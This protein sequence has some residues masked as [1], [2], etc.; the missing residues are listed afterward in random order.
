MI[1]Y[2]RLIFKFFDKNDNDSIS[3]DEFNSL[4]DRQINES[5]IIKE[6]N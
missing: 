5:K 4:F 3:Y 2:F 1:Y 6:I